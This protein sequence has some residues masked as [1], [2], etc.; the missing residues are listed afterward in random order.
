M[1][2][3]G[4]TIG[5]GAGDES[6]MVT[7]AQFFGKKQGWGSGPVWLDPGP[8]N[9]HRIRICIH[10]R[11]QIQSVLWQ[12]Y[13]VKIKKK[14]FKNRTFTHFHENFSIFSDKNNHHSNIRRNMFDVKKNLDV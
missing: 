1:V 9:F 11:I 13:V 12:C 3:V 8:E 4:I 7:P 10:I 6:K 14:Y 2:P 5:T